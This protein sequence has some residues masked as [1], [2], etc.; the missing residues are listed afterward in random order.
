MFYNTLLLCVIA[1]ERQMK[2]FYKKVDDLL[3]EAPCTCVTV[4]PCECVACAPTG[5]WG[6]R[7]Q[8]VLDIFILAPGAPQGSAG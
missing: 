6:T 5:H 8:P 7:T 2:K 3:H 1:E 4:R